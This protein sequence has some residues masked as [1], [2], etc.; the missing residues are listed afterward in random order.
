MAVAK[1]IYC[2]SGFFWV[3]AT[4]QEDVA[5]CPSL[6]DF[7]GHLDKLP[8]LGRPI[9]IATPCMG[10]DGCGFSCQL[11]N[12]AAQM[13][14]CYDVEE[15]YYDHLMHH[16][17]DLGQENIQLHLGKVAGDIARIPLAQLQ[18]PVDFLV[19]GPPC[20]PWAGQGVRTTQGKGCRD[21]KAKVFMAVLSWV[22]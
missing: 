19:A 17:Q 7:L 18:R 16:L 21:P 22:A 15:S 3:S 8:S 14:N 11:M 13:V 4:V 5:T 1:F 20:P 12:V 10:I 2:L 6:P 9:R